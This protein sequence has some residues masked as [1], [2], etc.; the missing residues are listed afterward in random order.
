MS[1][2]EILLFLTD[3]WCDWEASYVTAVANSFS[4][5]TVKTIGIDTEDKVSMGGLKVKVDYSIHDYQNFDHLSLLILPGGLSWEEHPYDEI[6]A[7]V[8]VVKKHE[9]PLAAICGATYFL[10]RH[11]FLNQ[12]NHTCDFL[13]LFKSVAA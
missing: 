3:R 5:Y 2:H 8:T 9:I 1:K 12:L 4:T 11:G 6:A 10:C 13:A 7:F